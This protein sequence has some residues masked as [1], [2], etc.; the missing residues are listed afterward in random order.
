MFQKRTW[1]RQEFKTTSQ[2]NDTYTEAHEET[3]D[4]LRGKVGACAEQRP[5]GEASSFL[6]P[7]RPGS[8][9]AFDSGWVCWWKAGGEWRQRLGLLVCPGK[10]HLAPSFLC[11]P[12][13]WA[14]RPQA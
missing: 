4:Q 9:R 10:L 1:S 11:F 13:A 3:E 14:C 2:E 8:S 5:H 12:T 6:S 7:P